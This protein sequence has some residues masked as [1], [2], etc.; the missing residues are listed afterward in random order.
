MLHH[1]AA[2]CGKC[3]VASLLH[4]SKF[5]LKVSNNFCAKFKYFIFIVL[6]HCT[7]LNMSLL[8]DSYFIFTCL[9]AIFFMLLSFCNTQIIHWT[10]TKPWPKNQD[11]NW[12]MGKW[13]VASLFLTMHQCSLMEN[14]SVAHFIK[15]LA[16]TTCRLKIMSS[17]NILKFLT[18]CLI[19]HLHIRH[20]LHLE[21]LSLWLDH[22][23]SRMAASG[24]SEDAP[25]NPML[26]NHP[27]NPSP[28][29][30]C[31]RHIR[32]DSFLPSG[33]TLLSVLLCSE[34]SNTPF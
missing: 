3:I 5:T 15:S 21:K 33:E 29:T 9:L 16:Y 27:E 14:K 12:V 22:C 34:L 13:I 2:L 7:R 6:L 8:K 20:A 24:C 19:L 23:S 25:R 10:K 17:P 18:K 11:L 26:W 31:L 1:W 4:A 32:F 28:A 30:L